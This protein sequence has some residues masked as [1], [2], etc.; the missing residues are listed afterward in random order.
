[1]EEHHTHIKSHRNIRR[2]ELKHRRSKTNRYPKVPSL[3]FHG[4]PRVR[5]KNVEV[6]RDVIVRRVDVSK[7]IVS[8]FKL[9]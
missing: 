2:S 9:R 6:V 3:I 7:N 5:R 8:V 1:S 4:I